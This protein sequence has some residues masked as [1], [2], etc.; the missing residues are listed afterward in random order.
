MAVGVAVWSCTG[1]SRLYHGKWLGPCF[2]MASECPYCGCMG[3]SNE[4]C[5]RPDG[6]L[7][8]EDEVK[9]CVESC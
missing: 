6:T 2:L 8:A 1:C 3:I 7:L 4:T 5:V 9:I